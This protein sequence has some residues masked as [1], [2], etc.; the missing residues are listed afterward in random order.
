MNIEHIS[1]LLY[2]T[3]KVILF[4]SWLHDFLQVRD[5]YEYYLDMN[6]IK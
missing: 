5:N 3:I 1:A 4:R 2:L 6:T